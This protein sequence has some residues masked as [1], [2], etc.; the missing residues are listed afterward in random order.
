IT[1]NNNRGSTR[2]KVLKSKLRVAVFNGLPSFDRRFLRLLGNSLEDFDF[3]YRTEKAAGSYYEGSFEELN[4]DSLDAFIFES[5]PTGR[6]DPD[7]LAKIMEAV[8]TRKIPIIWLIGNTANYQRL[9]GSA[10][11]LPFEPAA[12]LASRE[13]GFVKLTAGGELHP[14]TRLD[15]NETTNKLLWQELPP[16]ETFPTLAPREGSQVLLAFPFDDGSMRP[17]LFTFRVQGIKH[18]VLNGANISNWYFLLQEDPLREN[19]LRDFFERAVRWTV[20]REDINQVQIL[21][22]Q[23]IVNVGEAVIFSGQVFD[24]FYNVLSD[25]RVEIVVSGDSTRV[26]REMVAEGNGFF[27]QSFSGLPRGDYD[28]Q[29]RATRNGEQVGTR[30]GRITV[31]PFFLEYQN[32]RANYPLMAQIARES[33]GEVYTP[34]EFLAQFPGRQLNSRISYRSD[35][36]FLWNYWH[37]LLGLVLLL[38]SEWLL[39]KRWGLL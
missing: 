29:I 27:R 25:A 23:R 20:N 4:L 5:F 39:R 1:D 13:N 15:D 18:L 38:G 14:V 34:G 33:G 21:P 22:L 9:A 6:S 37:W 16:L 3:R 11:L 7:H 36:W 28:Y 35:E 26:E 24:G 17:A 10:D 31:K 2:V 32:T 30:S 12:R 19:L 8:A